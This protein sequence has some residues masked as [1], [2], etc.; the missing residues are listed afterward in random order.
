MIENDNI[1]PILV[2]CVKTV[3]FQIILHFCIPFFYF[4]PLFLI[5]DIKMMTSDWVGIQMLVATSSITIKECPK[6]LFLG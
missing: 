5:F 2:F 1:S 4:C 6:H 3:E